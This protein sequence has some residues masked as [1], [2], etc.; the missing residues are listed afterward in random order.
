MRSIS[1]KFNG[2]VGVAVAL[3]AGMAAVGCGGSDPTPDAPADVVGFAPPT[4]SLKANKETAPNMWVEDGAAD[5]SC[6][7]TPNSD[8]PTTMASK[9]M[10]KVEDFQTSSIVAAATV[11]IFTTDPATVASTAV[12][13]G[14][15]NLLID[16]PTGTKRFGF[17][18]K[19]DGS[20]D[21]LLVNQ[22]L[23]TDVAVHT[24]PAEIAIVSQGTANA[25]PALIGVTRTPGLGVIAGALRDCQGREI[26]NFIATVS[27]TKSTT[28]R[29]P[30]AP[31]YYFSPTLKT[32]ARNKLQ[33]SA[34]G[35]GLFM[36]IEIQPQASTYVQMW[37]YPTDAD[38]AA[39]SL[40]L[41]A[42][43]PVPVI[44]E[45][46]VTGSFEPLRQ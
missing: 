18:M 38:L 42:E 4:K 14:T 46:I 22:Y 19:A 23:K 6:L 11:S 5:L 35:N 12:S 10:T 26:S 37:G 41:I 1:S 39:G 44:A 15:G 24:A 36:V 13:D 20:M 21:T 28:T 34:S 45:T 17:K 9:L 30:N 16:V 43:L 40:K 8:M 25:L 31:T 27:S 32:P 29:L 2:H 33:P 7:N 3:V